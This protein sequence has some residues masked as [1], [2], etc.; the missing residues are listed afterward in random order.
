[1]RNERQ[2]K[3]K[4]ETHHGDGLNHDGDNGTAQRDLDGAEHCGRERVVA[5]EKEMGFRLIR[6]REGIE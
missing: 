1:M 2:E 4:K 5:R 3:R 6:E